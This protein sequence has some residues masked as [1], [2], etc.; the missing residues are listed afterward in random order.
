MKRFVMVLCGLAVSLGGTAWSQVT[1]RVSVA[2]SGVQGNAESFGASVSADV[3]YVAFSSRSTNLVFG[4]TNG[5]EDVFVRDR[6]TGITERVSVDSAGSQGNGPSSAPSISADGRY[7]AFVS[8]ATDLVAGDTN[9][10]DDVFVRDRQ[11]G[12]TERASVDSSGGQGV[13]ISSAPSISGDGR[14]VAFQSDA[15]LVTGDGN[16]STDIFVRDRQNSATERVSVD[17]SSVESDGHSL[18]PSISGDGRYVAFSSH[19]TNLVSAD[20]NAF[21]DVFVRDRQNLT[22]ERVSLETTGVE[23][24]NNSF[25][26]SI[27]ADGQWVAF[28]SSATNLILVDTN[29]VDDIFVHDRVSG[30]TE[31]ASVDAAGAEGDGLCYAPS[32]S[33]DGHYVAFESEA[34]N[35]VSA[36]T[37]AFSDVFIRDRQA[38]ATERVS[39]DSGGLE[40]DA[41]SYNPSISADGLFV[42]YESTATN[43]VPADTNAFSDVFVHDRLGGTSFTSICD[44]GGPGGVIACPCSNPPTGADRGCNNSALTG[45]AVLSASGGTSLSSDSLVFTTSGELPTEMSIVVQGKQLAAGGLIYG[46]GVRCVGGKLLRLYVKT[47]SGG[48]ITAPDFGGGDPSVSARSFAKGEPIPAGQSRW[49][50]VYYRDSV[51]QGGCPATSD[52][53]ATQTGE[54]VWSP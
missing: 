14:Y 30:T 3:R 20:T 1:Q 29:G 12:T 27:S 49:Y 54:V 44:P 10:V 51:I 31:R 21:E 53:N 32:I 26:P 40:G 4:D 47:A 11:N 50:F 15:T 13:A 52:F 48:S 34:T 45:G 17:S 16:V 25:S 2:S 39:V 43:L 33:S 42:A 41:Q 38:L 46:Q 22:T 28:T 8:G 9:A 36:D 18:E 37:N 23:G 19:A 5:L 7:V 24:D 6:L 35:L